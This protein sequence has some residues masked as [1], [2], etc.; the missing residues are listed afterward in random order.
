MATPR[1]TAAAIVLAFAAGAGADRAI[2]PPAERDAKIRS[3]RF[4]DEGPKVPT[5]YAYSIETSVDGAINTRELVCGN[6]GSVDS[7]GNAPFDHEQAKEACGAIA[8]LAPSLQTAIGN[9]AVEL[10][11]PIKK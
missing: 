3:I 10:S 5:R 11:R 9:M 7:Y 8:K 1:T 2:S 6:Q 4:L